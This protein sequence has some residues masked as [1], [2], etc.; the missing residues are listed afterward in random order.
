LLGKH[1]YGNPRNLSEFGESA[2]DDYLSKK[3]SAEAEKEIVVLSNKATRLL[4][5]SVKC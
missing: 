4:E 3:R 5:E 1:H 2:T